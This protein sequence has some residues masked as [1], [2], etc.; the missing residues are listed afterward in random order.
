MTDRLEPMNFDDLESQ[1]ADLSSQVAFPPTPDLAQAVVT[2]LR[3]GAVAPRR[4]L[5][6]PI[7]SLGR[8]LRMAAVL[9]LAIGGGT[10]A[11][12]FGLESLSIDRAPLPSP[13]V[14]TPSPGASGPVGSTLGL[15]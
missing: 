14:M 8:S 1:L 15:G 11:V 3:T 5:L 13:S 10:L 7:R 12:R 2:R 6:P 9:L 4:R